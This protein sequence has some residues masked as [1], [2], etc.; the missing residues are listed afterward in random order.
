M[1]AEHQEETQEA[2]HVHT[3]GGALCLDFVNTVSAR[4]WEGTSDRLAGYA[5][6]VAW[7][8]G[9]G[10]VSDATAA[11][12]LDAASKAA[13]EASA[14]LQR[15]VDLREALARIFIAQTE[16]M[17][18]APGDLVRLNAEL[19]LAMA[20]LRLQPGETCCVWMWESDT[21]ALD[22]VIWPVVRS[23]ADLLTSSEVDRVRQCAGDRCG[24]LFVDR[25]K[26]RSRRWCDMKECGNV[27]KVRRYRG[28]QKK[29]LETA[30]R[31]DRSGAS[32][33]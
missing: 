15:A 17:P 21:Q 25:S 4:G 32:I 22:Q 11:A 14:V 13:D 31:P 19:G 6:L 8:A 27:A 18:P 23:A 29:E 10:A 24:W 26:N 30:P 5:D 33:P 16:G 9:F 12:L 20:H 28:R 3:V 2:P 1:S 7:S